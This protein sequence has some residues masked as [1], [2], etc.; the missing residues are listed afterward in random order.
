MRV[1]FWFSLC[2]STALPAF[3]TTLT[4]SLAKSGSTYL[5][6][7]LVWINADGVDAQDYLGIIQVSIDG[8]PT[9]DAFCIDLFSNIGLATYNTTMVMP[10]TTFQRRVAWLLQNTLPSLTGV[11]QWAGLQLAIWDIIHD[12]G[13]GLSA[14]RI[15]T[16]TSHTTTTAVR[17]NAITY[18]SAS[19]GQ[20]YN[21]GI[22]YHPTSQSNGSPAQWLMS[23]M[24]TDGYPVPSPEPATFALIGLGLAA[25]WLK[26]PAR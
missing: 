12:G 6:G 2:L 5:E 13:D 8:S 21:V 7:A 1:L 3:G 19:L 16:A 15:R 17:N 18:L 14:G 26:R 20:S 4:T 10:N 23:S 24:Y 22:V 25:V 9:R 11:N